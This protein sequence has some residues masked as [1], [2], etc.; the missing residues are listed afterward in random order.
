MRVL[1]WIKRSVRLNCSLETFISWLCHFSFVAKPGY[2]IKT[3]SIN[4]TQEMEVNSLIGQSKHTRC[5][6]RYGLYSLWGPYPSVRG[7]A[8]R[9]CIGL[10]L[11]CKCRLPSL[12]GTFTCWHQHRIAYRT[13]RSHAP[14]RDIDL[15]NAKSL[16]EMHVGYTRTRDMTMWLL[17]GAVV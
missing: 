10:H 11:T 12:R 13:Q 14:I 15:M 16:L 6:V 17:W 4:D 7:R 2:V 5:S 1:L 9:D 8:L 3:L